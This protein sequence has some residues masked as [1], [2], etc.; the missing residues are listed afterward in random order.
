MRIPLKFIKPLSE[1][2]KQT[3]EEVRRNHPQFRVR[4]RAQALL[5]NARAYPITQLQDLFEVGRD[6]IS[7]WLNGWE[8]KGIVGIFDEARSGRPSIFTPDEKSK[9][10]VLVDEN[11]H[12]LSESAARL[13]DET[14]KQASLFTYKRFLKK[15]TM[16]GN[17]ADT[18]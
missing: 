8:S 12:Q 2:E 7:A 15:Q 16:F 13:Q 9:F 3:L 4:N 10:K 18:R 14:G 17:A 6:T 5:L 11:P 1:V